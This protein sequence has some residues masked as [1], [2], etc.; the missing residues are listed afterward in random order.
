MYRVELDGKMIGETEF[1]FADP[2]MGVVFGKIRFT[3]VDRPYSLFKDHCTSC[4]I[5]INQDEEDIGLIDT[6]TIA[7]LKVFRAD[8]IEI[9]GV[10]GASVIGFDDDG[11]EITILGVPY[12]FYEEEFPH[13]A[14]AYEERFATDNRIHEEK[15]EYDPLNDYA[16]GKAT[17]PTSI[18]A[19]FLKVILGWFKR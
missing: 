6:P 2:P 18:G 5:T 13:H 19:G 16:L 1:E 17:T 9:A 14:K 11:Y 3:T 12:P 15:S 7:G 10:P 4:G 8:G